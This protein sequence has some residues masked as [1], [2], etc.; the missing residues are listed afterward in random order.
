[1][2]IFHNKIKVLA[3]ASHWIH[4]GPVKI[5]V[6]TVDPVPVEVSP[7]SPTATVDI[8][9][10]NVGPINDDLVFFTTTFAFL[11]GSLD[12]T[13][14]NPITLSHFGSPFVGGA[15][16][17]PGGSVV[18]GSFSFTL[19]PA[20]SPT[21]IAPISTDF[22]GTLFAQALSNPAVLPSPLTARVVGVPEPSSALLLFSA[23]GLALI[24]R[25]RA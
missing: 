12:I 9:A 3:R 1:M 10:R 4:R 15:G 2:I 24:R 5:S 11:G 25:R 16:V 6:I 7:T 23:T 17:A 19:D 18:L 21:R 20:A 22:G 8:V 13:L 14:D